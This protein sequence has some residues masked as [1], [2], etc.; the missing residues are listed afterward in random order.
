MI[1]YKPYVKNKVIEIQE[2]FPVRYFSYIQGPDILKEAKKTWYQNVDI[3]DILP[4]EEEM[5]RN[6]NAV[7]VGKPPIEAI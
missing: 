5:K 7:T 3:D 4:C 1:K 6:V 2:L